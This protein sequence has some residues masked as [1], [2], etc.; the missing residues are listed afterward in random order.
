MNSCIDYTRQKGKCQMLD[1]TEEYNSE[2]YNN[3][4]KKSTDW[5]AYYEHLAEEE[6]REWEDIEND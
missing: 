4:Y 2:C 5:D 6:D 1:M 3:F